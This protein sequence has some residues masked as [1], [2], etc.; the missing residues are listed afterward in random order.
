MVYKVGKEVLEQVETHMC[1]C[2]VIFFIVMYYI[3]TMDVKSQNNIK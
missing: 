3:K 2:T 1:D